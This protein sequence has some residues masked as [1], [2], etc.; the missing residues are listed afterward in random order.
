MQFICILFYLSSELVPSSS[1]KKMVGLLLTR[2][3]KQ[4][5]V[6]GLVSVY[7]CQCVQK[8]SSELG[9]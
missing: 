3:S 6:I 5:N 8:K 4:G 1:N 7:I 2:A 9:I